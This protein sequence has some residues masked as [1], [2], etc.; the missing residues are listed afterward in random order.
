MQCDV[1]TKVGS[2]IGFAVASSFIVL[3]VV[4]AAD[5]QHAL[6]AKH[7]LR[8]WTQTL[9]EKCQICPMLR[10]GM[11]RLNSFDL[12]G[13]SKTFYLPS[14]VEEALARDATNDLGQDP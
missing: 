7:L 13:L 12:A 6:K 3:L 5:L 4:Q 14:H 9:K 10:L 8:I 2:R 11:L 1:L